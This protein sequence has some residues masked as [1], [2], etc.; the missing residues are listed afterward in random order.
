MLSFTETRAR[1]SDPDTSHAAAVH[2]GS[3]KACAERLAICRCLQDSPYGLTAWEIARL[4]A[5][6]YIEVQR[7]ISECAGLVKTA[8]RRDG[9][10]VWRAMA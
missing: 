8:E 7:R 6:D 10:R 2:A 3:V 4:T 5:I 9:R 1:N